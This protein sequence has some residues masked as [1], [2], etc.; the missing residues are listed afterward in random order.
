MM[1]QL[2]SGISI[3]EDTYIVVVEIMKGGI[4]TRS[5]LSHEADYCKKSKVMTVNW[6]ARVE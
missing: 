6:W 5:V 3:G 2:L 4:T 1:N